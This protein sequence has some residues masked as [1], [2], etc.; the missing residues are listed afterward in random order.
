[1]QYF[2]LN[3]IT[4]E[5]V[6]ELSLAI[7]TYDCKFVKHEE[8]KKVNEHLMRLLL[9]KKCTNCMYDLT[10]MGVIP[11]ESMQWSVQENIPKLN[12]THIRYMAT[13]YSRDIFNKVAVNNISSKLNQTPYTSKV[14]ADRNEAMGWL[15][16]QHEQLV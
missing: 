12:K 7:L 4:V 13:I 2:K 9:E 11:A 3:N 6:E 8:F 16:K 10:N 1:M 15:K 14:F 5:Y